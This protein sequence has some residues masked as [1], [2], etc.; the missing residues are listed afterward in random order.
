[1]LRKVDKLS[2]ITQPRLGGVRM[3]L[4]FVPCCPPLFPLFVGSHFPLACQQPR[5][6]R[7]QVLFIRQDYRYVVIY[8]TASGFLVDIICALDS[9]HTGMTYIAHSK[10]RHM[11][12]AVGRHTQ[13]LATP[14]PLLRSS[15]HI[16]PGAARPVIKK[17]Q[18]KG[19]PFSWVSS[20]LPRRPLLQVPVS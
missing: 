12:D 15:P 13:T 7:E 18:I 6:P 4:V 19:S 14:R 17:P 1:M 16:P 5:T 11:N 3:S 10:K 8:F 9:L 2:K 20:S